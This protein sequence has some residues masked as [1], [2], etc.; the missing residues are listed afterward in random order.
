MWA[1]SGTD[2]PGTPAEPYSRQWVVSRWVA[3]RLITG[4]LLVPESLIF[5]DVRYYARQLDA[6]FGPAGVQDVLREYPAPALAVF[7][8]PWWLAGGN[9]IA[10]VVT[11]VLLMVAVDAAFSA[12]L[13]RA[14]KRRPAPGVRLWLLLA[15]LLGPLVFTRFDLVPATLAGAA[16]LALAA[17]RP[18]GAGLLTAAG[19]AVKLWPAG[20]LPALL[21]PRAG[22]ARLLAGF[23]A[24]VI[25]ALGGTLLICG[26]SRLVSPLTWQDERGLQIESFFAV[27]LLW[28]RA[29]Q[30]S[31]WDVEYTRFFA[32][33][34]EGP[35]TGVLI[36]LSTLATI[37]A[38]VLLAWLWWRCM[39]SPADRGADPVTLAGLLSIAIACLLV[40]TNKTLSPQYLLWVGG[41]LAAVGCIR[42]AEPTVARMS[43][44]LL[45]TCLVTQ[46]IYPLA[47]HSVTEQSWTN[48]FGAALLTTR[49]GLLVAVAVVA[50]RRLH[51]L[52]RRPREL[53]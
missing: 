45:A 4:L 48:V 20:L 16:V 10:Y 31:R 38:V 39:R 24:G 23:G 49:D 51:T 42:P 18:A 30:P 28:A 12:A 46:V 34:I 13:W 5:G 17:S 37:A 26:S 53:A 50:V 22:R 35:G 40:M 33:Q 47:Y 43:A 8:P 2:R 9:R 21:I 29:V 11:F 15:P 44:L 27:P 52:T 6:L 36:R 25:V 3:T 1:P 41:L 14:A 19:A 32:Y 7:V